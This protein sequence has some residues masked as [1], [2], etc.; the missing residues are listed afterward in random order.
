MKESLMPVLSKP[1][2][3]FFMNLKFPQLFSAAFE[4][5]KSINLMLFNRNLINKKIWT[6]TCHTLNLNKH[7]FSEFQSFK[8]AQHAFG[9]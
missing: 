6:K 8:L 7:K 5:S 1:T 9:M 2:V 4:I 3:V